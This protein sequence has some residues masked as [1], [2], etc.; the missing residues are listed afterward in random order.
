MQTTHPRF[1]YSNTEIV[2]RSN[3]IAIDDVRDLV[4]HLVADAPP[5]NW[6]RIDNSNMIQKVVALLVPGL[7][8][9]LLSLP[10]LPTAATSN[11][12]LPLS[13]PLISPADLASGAASIPFIASTFSHACPT[14][15]PGD[16]TRM[17]SVLSSFFTGPVSGEEKKRRLMQRVQSEINKSDPMRYLLTLEQMIE[18]DYPIPSYM[19]DVFEKP[20][21]WVETPEPGANEHKAN[22]RIYAIDCEMMERN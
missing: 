12:N 19:A 18:N 8:P 21:G 7:T 6:L 1:M 16:Q 22:P 14:R 20:Q 2:K 10:P 11:P 15:A 17:H 13:I 4:L 3:A 5:P 9:D